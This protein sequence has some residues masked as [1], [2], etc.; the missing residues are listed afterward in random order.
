MSSVSLNPKI[1]LDAFATSMTTSGLIQVICSVI[2]FTTVMRITECDKHLIGMLGE[3]LRLTGIFLVPA[4]TLLTFSIN[5]ALPSAA[6]CAA[7]VGSIM[8]PLLI[9]SG[10][11]PAMAAATVYSGTYGSMLSPGLLQIPFIAKLAG[12]SAVDVIDNHKIAV[13]SSVVVASLTLGI[14]A[15]Y[16][17]EH[18]GYQSDHEDFKINTDFK[19]N[20][21]F[22]LVNVI[23]LLIL[24]L[25]FTG[26]VPALKMGIAQAMLIGV[27]VAILVTKTN[28]TYVITK[29]FDGMGEAYSNILGIIITAT[30]FVSGIKALGTEELFINFLISNPS[31]AGIG[32]TIGPALLAIVTGSGDVA[33]L[34]F[35]EAITPYAESFGMSIQNMGSL[36]A[37]SG[38]IGRTMSP[39]AGAAII[40][41]GF[42]RIS[43]IDMVKRT[44]FGMF[45]GLIC[46]YILLV[47]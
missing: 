24:I 36:A 37:I 6:G 39:L 2:G 38:A 14:L 11:R 17:K 31:I 34:S 47:M 3:K 26:I 27:F 35:N 8:I 30:V 18:K 23:P 1:A 12:I 21:L 5:I 43:A 41:A 4:T 7:A 20:H 22:A 44:F 46:A 29:F 28:P 32:A 16:L 25:G 9:H 42:A 13:I 15:V 10:V 45:L 40:C 19:V 33:S